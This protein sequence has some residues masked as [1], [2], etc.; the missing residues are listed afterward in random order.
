MFNTTSSANL[1]DR[2]AIGLSGLCLL[3]C[4]AS[5][6]IVTVLATAGGALLHPAIHE[7]GLAAAILL[8]ILGLGRGY[9]VHRRRVPA[10]LGVAGIVSMATALTVPHGIGEAVYT[11]A[12]V[13]LVA[14]AH[15]LNSRVSA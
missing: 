15:F 13:A 3:H 6:V 7:F 11:M 8:A 10:L 5:V 2:L 9:L 1:L 14:S 4:A 12:G